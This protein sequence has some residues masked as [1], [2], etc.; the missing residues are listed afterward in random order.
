MAL[1]PDPNTLAAK[2]SAVQTLQSE[3]VFYRDQAAEL[4][5]RIIE[6]LKS[7]GANGLAIAMMY[8]HMAEAKKMAVDT[9]AKL[10]PY[11]SPRLQSIEVTKQT[12]HK[13]VIE[14]PKRIDSEQDWIEN[15][16]RELKLIDKIKANVED[17]EILG[18]KSREVAHQAQIE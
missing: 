4:I 2:D 16:R 18:E 17:A 12:T 9:A 10:A 8:K 14:S 3:M 5:E 1:Q 13:Y 15:T 6:M 11:Q 7:Q